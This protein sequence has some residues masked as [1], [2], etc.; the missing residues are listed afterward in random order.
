MISGIFSYFFSI[1]DQSRVSVSFQDHVCLLIFPPLFFRQ[2]TGLNDRVQ[3]SEHGMKFLGILVR[4]F[5]LD[6]VLQ[7]PC[8]LIFL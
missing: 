4:Y 5:N 1:Q 7:P 2:F 8:S 3:Q 6:H